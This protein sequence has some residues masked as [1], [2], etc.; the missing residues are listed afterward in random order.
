MGVGAAS[1]ALTTAQHCW[2][3]RVSARCRATAT[4]GSSPEPSSSK[5][6]AAVPLLLP[7]TRVVSGGG[8]QPL[9]AYFLSSAG[10]LTAVDARGSKLFTTHT[11]AQFAAVDEPKLRSAETAAASGAV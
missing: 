11:A 4:S 6:S 7:D 1:P 8:G 5:Q 9:V 3:D 10:L 2:M